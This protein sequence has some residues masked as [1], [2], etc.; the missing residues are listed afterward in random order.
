MDGRLVLCV[1]HCLNA[2]YFPRI[3]DHD[4]IRSLTE[5]YANEHG[6]HHGRVRFD[7]VPTAP[8]TE[9]AVSLKMAVGSPALR[10]SRTNCD[11]RGRLVDCDLE[12]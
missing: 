2:Q 11:Q 9:A 7:M 1:E 6:I 12:F 10:I 4:L 5:L 3:L 8:H